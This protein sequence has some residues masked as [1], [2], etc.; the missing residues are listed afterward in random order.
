MH[1]VMG[2]IG[3]GDLGFLEGEMM[4]VVKVRLR[5]IVRVLG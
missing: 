2:D 1:E 3:H 5:V 4:M